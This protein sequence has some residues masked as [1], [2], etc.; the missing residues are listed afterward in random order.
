MRRQRT[1]EVS[2]VK[3]LAERAAQAQVG[4]ARATNRLWVPYQYKANYGYTTVYSERANPTIVGVEDFSTSR[5]PGS[6]N[7]L[8]EPGLRIKRWNG[9]VFGTAKFTAI[10]EPEAGG[11]YRVRTCRY[12][13][14]YDTTPTGYGLAEY[15]GVDLY[16]DPSRL[17]PH[18]LDGMM[19]AV[20]SDHERSGI[21]GGRLYYAGDHDETGVDLGAEFAR[22]L[23]AMSTGGTAAK[24]AQMVMPLVNTFRR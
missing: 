23:S 15:R 3:D 16:A 24:L 18:Q 7:E 2:E 14:D 21:T 8:L 19:V 17:S 11:T 13:Y 5:Q 12:A 1:P 6:R 4:L 20:S 10:V 22:D 9:F